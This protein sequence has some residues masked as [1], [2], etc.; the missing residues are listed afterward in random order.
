MGTIQ[1]NDKIPAA[2]RRLHRHIILKYGSIPKVAKKFDVAR[3][4][5]YYHIYR[6]QW[7]E[8]LPKP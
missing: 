3:N 1:L 2:G 5:V 8:W 6:G 4:T 7:P